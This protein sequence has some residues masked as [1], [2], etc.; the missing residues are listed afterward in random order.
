MT[1]RFFNNAG[2]NKPDINYTLPPL[3]RLDLA[4]IEH[5][6]AQQRYFVLHAPRQTGKTTTLLALMD[7]LNQQG[8]YQCLYVNVESAQA[9]REDVTRAMRVMMDCMVNS[10]D[11]YLKDT[12]LAE[13]RRQ[14]VA[15]GVIEN[16]I[17]KLLGEW[18]QRNN[19]PIVLLLDEVDAL[20]GDTLISLLRQ[21]RAGYA[22]R[23]AAFPQSV[24]LC[25]VRDVRDYRIHSSHTKEIITGGSAFNIKAK[26]LRMGNFNAT[27]SRA[28]L[29]QHTQETGQVF[30]EEALQHFWKLT[31]GQPWLLNALA[32]QVTFEM[33]QNRDRSRVIDLDAVNEAKEALILRRDTHLDQLTDKLKEPRVRSVIA[34]LLMCEDLE[35]SLEDDVQYVFDLG[36]IARDRINGIYLANPIYREIIPRQLT[37]VQ[38]LNFEASFQSAWYV[39]PD[40]RLDMPKLLSAFQAFFREHSSA[41]ILNIG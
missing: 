37:Y 7:Y 3:E 6:I 12:R 15:D 29:L 30:T 39:Q 21:I 20:V 16:G 17:E 22:Q 26:S 33:K 41:S 10:A 14:I 34:P 1:E 4:E 40:G 27:E 28:L 9:M 38:R 23:P 25:G 32:Y 13:I 35:D 8:I 18:A 19:K 11:W 2:P 31:Q 36:L 5:Y 24:I